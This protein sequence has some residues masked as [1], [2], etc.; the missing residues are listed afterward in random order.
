MTYLN[1]NLKLEELTERILSSNQKV[2]KKVAK[3]SFP[4]NRFDFSQTCT[5]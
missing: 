4:R 5:V 1:F 3:L 2:L